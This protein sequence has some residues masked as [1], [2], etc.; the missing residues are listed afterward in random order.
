MKLEHEPVEGKHPSKRQKIEG[1]KEA[2][3]TAYADL[4]GGLVDMVKDSVN[5]RNPQ[6]TISQRRDIT[7]RLYSWYATRVELPKDERDQSLLALA[8]AVKAGVMDKIA[9]S[10]GGATEVREKPSLFYRNR[11]Y[12]LDKPLTVGRSRGADVSILDLSCTVSRCQFLVIAEAGLVLFIP[13]GG[14]GTTSTIAVSNLNDGDSDEIDGEPLM[15]SS[16]DDPNVL[17]FLD[18]RAILELSPVGGDAVTVILNPKECIVCE[19]SPR[20]QVL[21]C[22]HFVTCTYCTGQLKLCPICQ[23]E[24]VCATE[25]RA[26][27]SFVHYLMTSI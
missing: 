26:L 5:N 22:C 17:I 13:V 4:V 7:A 6:E 24:I 12:P 23:A 20:T 2:L 9:W 15:T 11:I 8:N 19:N 1:F 21:S 16:I 3:D 14:K 27:K 25:T 10:E 18:K